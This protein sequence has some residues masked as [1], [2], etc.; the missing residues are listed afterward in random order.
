MSP[1][2]AAP[3]WRRVALIAAVAAALAAVFAAYLQPG[4]MLDLATRLWSCF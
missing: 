2:H 4:L 1:V 3:G